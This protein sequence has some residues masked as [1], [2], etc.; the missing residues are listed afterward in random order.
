LKTDISN[1]IN[2]S[3]KKSSKKKPPDIMS[4]ARLMNYLK[5]DFAIPDDDFF[6]SKTCRKDVYQGIN[7]MKR[8]L[9]VKD[10][11]EV[12]IIWLLGYF[13][14]GY[15]FEDKIECISCTILNFIPKE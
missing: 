11:S 13:K 14:R 9:K 2:G 5:Y 3:Y 4:A 15:N 12:I 1:K 10:V 7:V 6:N 8:L